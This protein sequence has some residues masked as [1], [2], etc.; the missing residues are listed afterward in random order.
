MLEGPTAAPTD[1]A[2]LAICD[3]VVVLVGWSTAC[4]ARHEGSWPI[5]TPNR[6]HGPIDF[7]ESWPKRHAADY[8]I[9]RVVEVVGWQCSGLEKS[10]G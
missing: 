10:C 8:G 5:N 9:S 3:R 7:A 6:D 1:E 4:C 2:A